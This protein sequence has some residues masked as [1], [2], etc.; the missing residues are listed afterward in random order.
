MTPHGIAAPG[1][2]PLRHHRPLQG[3][4][5]AL[6][7]SLLGDQVFHLALPWIVYNLTG[8]ALA[9]GSMYAIGELPVLLNPLLGTL[10]DRMNRR[11]LMVAADLL[12]ALLVASIPLLWYTGQLRLWHLFVL[13]AVLTVLGQIYNVCNFAIIP[14]VV[15]QEDLAALNSIT[16]SLFSVT[17]TVGPALAGLLIG[18]VGAPI[19]LLADAV[20]YLATT[21][22]LI[23]FRPPSAPPAAGL[24]APAFLRETW[25]GVRHYVTHRYLLPLG[26]FMLLANAG[27]SL[28]FT[29]LIYHYRHDLD[30]P[31][32]TTGLL[33]GG[34]GLAATGLTLI[35]PW[36]MKRVSW[37][38]VLFTARLT[39][40]LFVAAHA[41]ARQLAGLAATIIPGGAIDAMSGV[42]S[43]TL[44]QKVIPTAMMGRV[45]ATH[46]L[47]AFI[48]GPIGAVTGGIIGERWGASLAIALGGAVIATSSLIIPFSPL[49]RV[50]AETGETPEAVTA[51]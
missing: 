31:A 50:S 35:T 1:R 40:G 22:A 33:F 8:S 13:G 10:V 45:Q 3:F 28:C 46:L 49:R 11:R 43:N 2:L 32:A 47:V 38:V 17:G 12:R 24:G 44:R 19:A 15:P 48:G 36:L 6:L 41:P 7:V 51:G 39:S 20:S 16:M 14:L 26:V 5:G 4:L 27:F 30:L 9:M 21:L 29:Q 18:L 37:W 25:G 23:W 42:V 34:I